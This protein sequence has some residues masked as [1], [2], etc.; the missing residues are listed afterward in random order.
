MRFLDADKDACPLGTCR[1][2]TVPAACDNG[3]HAEKI[4]Q[5]MWR[6]SKTETQRPSCTGLEKRPN[7]HRD[8][9]PTTFAADRT[10]LSASVLSRCGCKKLD[11]GSS[12]VGVYLHYLMNP[13]MINRNLYMLFGS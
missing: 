2:L 7:P 6:L 13:E 11:R 3:R 4:L 5:K 1:L 10:R 12:S 8:G 9:G